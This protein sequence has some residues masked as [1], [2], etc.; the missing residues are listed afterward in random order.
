LTYHGIGGEDGVAPAALERQLALVSRL[1]RVVPL[2]EAIRLLGRSEAAEVAA[3]T[4][5]DGYRDF[6]ELAVPAIAALDLHATLFVPAGHIGGR[7]RWDEGRRP[8]RQLL[9][10]GEL[11]NLDETH[12]EIGGHGLNHI[13]MAGLSSA[14]LR[15]E[16]ETS[17]RI[18][19]DVTARE[20]RLFAFP[21]GQRGDFDLAAERA[22]EAAGYTAACSTCFGRGSTPSERF[23]L[24]RVSVVAGD[25]EGRFLRKLQGNY[26]WV[27]VKEALAHRVRGALGRRSR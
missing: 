26:D 17:R 18:L 9:A 10:E 2:A 12:V 5:D 22:V 15:E 6:A 13:S 27:A 3:L 16:T 20:I 25:D 24:R 11:R 19:E 14:R 21:N 1:K 23:R 8:T 7:N 4:F